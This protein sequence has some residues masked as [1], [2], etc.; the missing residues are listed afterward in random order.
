[1]KRQHLLT[2]RASVCPQ[3]VSGKSRRA[4]QKL[5]VILLMSHFCI[6]GLRPQ[7]WSNTYCRCLV[8]YGN[9]RKAL[10]FPTLA[11]ARESA[12]LVSRTVNLWSTNGCC[13]V[14]PAR[15]HEDIF[16][17]PIEIFSR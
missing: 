11:F 5:K 1:M 17:Q 8:T 16:A 14:D 3:N 6:H 15:H 7:G 9:G 4:R 2:G 12:P 13:A 10:T